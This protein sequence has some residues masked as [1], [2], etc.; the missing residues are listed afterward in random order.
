MLK[1]PRQNGTRVAYSTFDIMMKI[2]MRYS[3]L[4]L[5]I[6]FAI[7]T[8]SQRL[9]G[10]EDNYI[11]VLA[12]DTK[13]VVMEF[14]TPS[15]GENGLPF[16]VESVDLEGQTFQRLTLKGLTYIIEEGKPQL[17]IKGVLLQIPAN[18]QVDLR[19]ESKETMTYSGYRIPYFDEAIYAKDAFYPQYPAEIEAL[20]F[21]RDVRVANV[22][23][24][25]IQYNPLR[26]EVK[27]HRRLELTVSFQYS[28]QSF[29]RPRPSSA[30]SA[31]SRNA[32]GEIE[33]S[34][35][36]RIYRDLIVN[37]NPN[38]PLI[39]SISPRA[40]QKESNLNSTAYKLIVDQD[41]I[42]RLT[43]RDLKQAGIDV[44]DINPKTLELSN[45]GKAVPIFVS[46]ENDGTFD[47]MDYIEFQGEF[48]RGTYS[49]FGEYT[50]ENV[51]W[52]SWG[53]HIGRGTRMAIEDATPE[54]NHSIA[55]RPASYQAA[56]HF[57]QDNFR[58]SLGYVDERRDIWFWKNMSPGIHEYPFELHDIQQN[59]ESI[60]RIMFHGHTLSD[61]H[62]SAFVNGASLSS[63]RWRGQEKYLLEIPLDSMFL[64]E[65]KNVLM[66]TLRTDTS[67]GKEDRVYLNW[68]EVEH[69]RA[70]RAYNNRIEFEIPNKGLYQFKITGFT[71]PNIEIYKGGFSKL[72]NIK[73][74]S[75]GVDETGSINYAV[76]FFDEIVQPTKYIALTAENKK[77]PKAIVKDESSKLRSSLNGA[78][79]IIIVYDEFYEAVLPLAKYRSNK[80]RVAVVKVQDIYDEF[81]FGLLTP[82]AIRGFIRYAYHYWRPPAPSY[83]L[84]V[85]DASWDFRRGKNYVPAYYVNTY[86]WGQTASDHFYACVNGDD[87]LPDLFIGR[88]TTRTKEAT[89]AVVE[90]II[91][92]E[93]QPV[94]GDWRRC[95]L[96]LAAAGDFIRDSE[97]LLKDYVPID[98][99]YKVARVYTDPNSSYYGDTAQLLDFW[100][101]G[102]S[103]VHFTGH[104]GGHI[105]AD[106]SLFTLNDVQFLLNK[107]RPAFVTSFTCFTSYFDD[108]GKSGLNEK[109]VNLEEGGA[110]AAF[111]STGLG[112]V[113]GDYYM[114]Q[115]LFNSLFRN[116]SRRIGQVIVETKVWMLLNTYHSLKV[117]MISLLDMAFEH[118]TS[119]TERTYSA[120]FAT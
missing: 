81:S 31:D 24:Y 44:A 29:S 63:I 40:P 89:R 30:P 84:L 5:F 88:I 16:F 119:Q 43:Y 72:T 107:N 12:S 14:V 36:Q 55:A 51:Y 104:G 27:F 109:L 3:C 114:E 100:N 23:I 108:P 69:W 52:L 75:D 64:K 21:L 78:D 71:N 54:E 45:K 6:L 95:L 111:G 97:Q 19:V 112:W 37:F 38:F 47:F 74:E 25:P 18:A 106:S 50:T 101:A 35:F 11:R 33:N 70:F 76:T 7:N 57:E 58:G 17:P 60:I 93:S 96:M 99:G 22:S 62:I 116:G 28:R 56:A 20:G 83:I 91:R 2:L 105:W 82:E 59:T 115:G 10:A 80:F 53:E 98:L 110:I 15:L 32:S 120:P 39:K 46:G 79:Y 92:Y 1:L 61:H 94:L 65:G 13:S 85:G 118:R 67:A 68:F 87:P 117:N 9:I 8:S 113:K 66:L 77:S 48:N 34:D 4:L 49:L 90:K 41:G 86:K 102:S 26:N 103:F 73:I 42:Y